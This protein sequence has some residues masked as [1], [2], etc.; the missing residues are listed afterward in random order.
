MQRKAWAK[1]QESWSGS[2]VDPS[3]V[4]AIIDDHRIVSAAITQLLESAGYRVVDAY[5]ETPDAIVATLAEHRPFLVFLDHDLGPAGIGLALVEAAA[6]HGVVVAL[7]AAEDRL[8]HAQYLAAGADGVL[9]KTNGPGEVL[10]IVELAL[11]SE[12]VTTAPVRDQLMTDLRTARAAE[13]RRLR[14]FEQL[15]RREAETLQ[16]LCEGGVASAIAEEWVVSLAT[17][18]SHIR[19]VLVKLGVSSQLEAVALAHQ[20]GWLGAVRGDSSIVMMTAP[21]DVPTMD[22]MKRKSAG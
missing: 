16:R 12:P 20:S 4:I 1:A 17:V 21:G 7:T 13:A 14:P 2:H 3:S 8:L 6:R 18:R 11:A 5:R 22:S 9:C 10:A 19:S 15:T